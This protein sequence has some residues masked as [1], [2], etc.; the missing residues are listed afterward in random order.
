MTSIMKI[1]RSFIPV[2]VSNTTD[3]KLGEIA[4]FK[5]YKGQGR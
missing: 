1:K 3:L 5:A 2:K 4:S